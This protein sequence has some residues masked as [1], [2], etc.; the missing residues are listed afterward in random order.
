M[1]YKLRDRI[2][3]RSYDSFGY[4]TDNSEYGYRFLYRDYQDPGEMY[5]SKSGAVMLTVLT[6]KPRLI[7]EIVSDLL[8]IFEGV[9]YSEL[10]HD[11]IEF[12]DS[13]VADGF[14][15]SGLTPS[16]CNAASRNNITRTEP[17]PSSVTSTNAQIKSSDFLRSLHIE[18]ASECNE[19]C[20]HC[21]IPHEDKLAL[22]K[23]D[24]FYRIIKEGRAL[25]IIHV[26]ISGGEP[27]LHPE[28]KSFLHYCRN[29]DLSINVLSNLT[30][31]DKS[32]LDE[33]RK[34]PLL[35]VQT[36]LYSMDPVVH[37]RITGIDGGFEK[38]KAAIQE[39]ASVGIPVQISCPVMKENKDTF[40]DVVKWAD[41]LGIGTAVQ[42]QIFAQYDHTGRNLTHRLSVNEIAETV[43]CLIEAGYGSQWLLDASEKERV[44]AQD[45]ICSICRYML[46]IS[47]TGAVYPCVGWQTNVIDTLNE[48][49]LSEIWKKSEKVF[50][51]RQIQRSR[52]PQCVNCKDRGYCT[53][54]MMSNSNEN[55]DGDPFRIDPFNCEV[56]SAIHSVVNQYKNK[57][58]R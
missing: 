9:K 23:P 22:I 44:R 11:V 14:L 30:L 33:M 53:V 52:F 25:N 50:Y 51:L 21:Y 38:T 28:L 17:I 4:L 49:S 26:T 18:V 10:K 57:N 43:R 56:A 58:G 8:N 27:L 55:I 15:C 36:S 34:N 32:M 3:F 54:C 1:Y 42:P 24:L 46:C 13:L 6:R 12:Y 45:P 39:I 20:V 40:L 2:L 5:I 19:R 41:N 47:A 48:L 35:S 29:M 31:L 7:D 37:D 16:D